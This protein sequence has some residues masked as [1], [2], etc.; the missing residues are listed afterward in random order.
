MTD[1]T[2]ENR[3][4]DHVLKSLIDTNKRLID[5]IKSW[6]APL[7]PDQNEISTAEEKIKK[8]EAELKRRQQNKQEG[9]G[10]PKRKK[11]KTKKKKRKFTKNKSSKKKNKFSKKKK[12]KKTKNKKKS[13]SR[14]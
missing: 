9:G 7:I 4:P 6:T 3:W 5:S 8:I 14:R 11:R 1:F 10:H 2:D 12:K 13:K